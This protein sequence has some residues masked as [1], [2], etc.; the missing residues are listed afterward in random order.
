MKPLIL[1]VEDNPDDEE[2]TLRALR[3]HTGPLEVA[4]ARGG[5]EALERLA[6]ARKLDRMPAVVLLDL[7]LPGLDG[8]GV[9]RRVRSQPATAHLPV[10]VLTSSREQR[11][12]DASYQLGANSYIQKPIDSLAFTEAVRAIGRYWLGLNVAPCR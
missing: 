6:G 12:V 4:V 3:S 2:L 9:L 1:L 5:Q 11:D 8:L 10:V 7:K